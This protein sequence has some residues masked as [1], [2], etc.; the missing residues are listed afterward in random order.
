MEHLPRMASAFFDLRHG[1]VVSL[2]SRGRDRGV[3]PW[4]DGFCFSL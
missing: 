3:V 4:F 1:R 2:C